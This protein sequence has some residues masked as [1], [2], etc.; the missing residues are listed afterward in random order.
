MKIDDRCCE[1]CANCTKQFG[2]VFL[3]CKETEC[4]VTKRFCCNWYVRETNKER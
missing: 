1:T 2:G 3:L 4:C